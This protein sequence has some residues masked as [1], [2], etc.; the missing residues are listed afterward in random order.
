MPDRDHA[1]AHDEDRAQSEHKTPALE[2]ITAALGLI[3]VTGAIALL[4]YDAFEGETLPR[5]RAVAGTVTPVGDRYRVEITV[6]N[7][8]GSTAASVNVE[9]ALTRSGRTIETASTTFDYVPS[10]SRTTGGMF[11]TR[12]PRRYR[13]ELDA[14]AYMD[15]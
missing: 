8:G 7:D 3:L 14:N 2:W 9:G 6:Q 13:I 12:D 15:P 5:L 4:V 11:F 1:D 10:H